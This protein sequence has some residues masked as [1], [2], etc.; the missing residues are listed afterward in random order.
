MA[1]DKEPTQS[2]LLHSEP[3]PMSVLLETSLPQVRS[4]CFLFSLVVSLVI[5]VLLE[6]FIQ[7]GELS[8][9]IG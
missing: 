6:R 1:L 9:L 2:I 3:D 4:C 5:Y 8:N 7:E